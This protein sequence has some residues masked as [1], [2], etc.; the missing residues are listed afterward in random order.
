M[1]VHLNIKVFSFSILL[2]LVST[3]CSSNI[4]NPV[5]VGEDTTSNSNLTLDLS[6]PQFDW[7]KYVGNDPIYRNLSVDE[8]E[9][10]NPVLAGFYP[11]PSITRAGDDYYLVTSSFAYF[12]GIPIFHSKDLVHWHQIGN[13]IDRPSQLDFNGLDL[14]AGVFAPSIIYHKG[15]YYVV[16][17]PVG[18]GPNYIVTTTDPGGRWSDPI[19]LDNIRGI[20]PSMFF[21]DDGSVY[22]L[23]TDAP[24]N[25]EYDGQQAI[26][27]QK[28]DLEQNKAIGE[29]IMLVNKGD[30]SMS[31]Q[32]IW[33][34]AP[35]MMKVDGKYYL[36]DAQ[37]GTGPAHTEVVFRSDNVNGP[38]I[39]YENNPILTQR[40]IHFPREFDVQ[41]AG[42]ADMVQTQNGEW[43]AV[44]L[45][46]R[47][48]D[49]KHFNTGRETYLLPVTWK[50][51]WPII[52]KHGDTIPVKL[53]RPDLP[54]GNSPSP[55]TYGNFTYIDNFDSSD[56]ADY[57]IMARTPMEKW[58]EI[59]KEGFLQLNAR[60]EKISGKGNPSFIGR[61]QQHAYGAASVKMIYDP[62]K[63]GDV[64]G[65][66]A[67]QAE[68]YHYILGVTLNE[69][70]QKEIFVKK[71]EGDKKNVIASKVLN[72]VSNNTYF[73]KITFE[74]GKYIFSYALNK[75]DWKNLYKDAD[76][77]VLSTNE[78]G[79]FVGTVIGM[80]AYSN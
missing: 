52:L 15:T 68:N 79:G 24:A 43:W 29:R 26:W 25:Q 7:F 17:T 20:D 19:F 39:P 58:W 6:D 27:L 72:G 46:V 75:N 66:V 33:I 48:Y 63:L 65:L 73:L 56:L 2:M 49:G 31:K 14:S 64:A 47:P 36:I 5:T 11:D 44:F 45:G 51:G 22:F 62:Q 18:V 32:P 41:Y 60:P 78:A 59:T 77:T 57:W 61:R 38:F 67:F 54:L 53:K 28:Y 8:G 12:P 37:G 71:A 21:D 30:V 40:D 9:Y 70:G 13:V 69:K 23:T 1:S 16:N 34:E 4:K 55:P 10:L 74:G 35:H 3:G 76:G 80:Y 42:H 50:E